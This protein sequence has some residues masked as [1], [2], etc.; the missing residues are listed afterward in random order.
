MSQCEK[1]GIYLSFFKNVLWSLGGNVGVQLLGLL[2]N[3]IL[4]RLLT[5]EIFGVV[6]ITMIFITLVHNTQEAGFSSV[7]VNSN[8]LSNKLVTITYYSN[9]IFS[10]VLCLLIWFF[11]PLISNFYGNSQIEK[12]LYYS[13]IGLIIGSFGIT[14]R[15]LLTR[16]SEFKVLTMVDLISEILG[17]ILTFILI[18][19]EFYYIAVSA[20]VMSRPAF[21]AIMMLLV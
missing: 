13:I 7:I 10:I 4:A 2:T 14:F 19:Y 21:R 18:F 1:Q 6:A 20:R 8:T 3:I 5:P 11:A 15:G 12:L 9:I 17:I 16:R